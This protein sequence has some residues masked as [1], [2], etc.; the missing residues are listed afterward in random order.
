MAIPESQ[1]DTWSHQ[2]AIAQS[3]NTY[4]A[5]KNVLEAN[6]TKYAQED[7]EVFLQG[8]YG[9][10]TNVYAESDVDVVILLNS[11]F[12]KDL[13]KLSTEEKAAYDAARLPATYG[14]SQ[15]KDDV[16]STLTKAFGTAVDTSGRNA[17]RI[18]GEGNRRN[19][20]VVVATQYRRYYKF[21]S[22]WDQTYD[23]GLCFWAKD[24]VQIINYPKQHSENCSTKHQG[25]SEWFKPV[26]RILKNMRNRMV[27]DG[28]I[29]TGIAPSYFLEGLLYNAPVI[30][31]GKSYSD[32]LVNCLNWIVEA[33]RSKFV[34]ANEQYYLIRDT[35][36]T[37]AAAHCDLFL[38]KL[39]EFWNAWS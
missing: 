11:T 1:L 39:L 22:F 13:S 28:F 26:V 10:D 8:S 21:K 5:I 14:Y 30:N 3:K 19:A 17:I 12:Y 2:G 32:T 7:F 33:D 29:G 6:N 4:A 24:A 27:N 36:V 23:T 18:K 9:N 37:W 35:R 38:K 31:F 15:F 34:C 20:D 25:T 16:V